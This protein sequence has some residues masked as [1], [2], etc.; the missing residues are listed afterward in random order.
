M[1]NESRLGHGSV[2]SVYY[3]E[4]CVYHLE[5]TLYFASEICVAGSVYDIDTDALVVDGCVLGE[6]RDAALTLQVVA[7]HD[8]LD[9][10]FVL[11]VYARLLE[12]GVDNG[13]LAV[14]NVSDDRY[15]AHVLDLLYCHTNSPVY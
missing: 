11:A 4:H 1:Q 2:E 14:V 12:H 15:V 6:D 9:D 3:E 10:F 8:L 5:Y 13:G 7:V